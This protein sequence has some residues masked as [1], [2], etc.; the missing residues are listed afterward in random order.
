MD[1]NSLGVKGIHVF[2][3]QKDGA[4]KEEKQEEELRRGKSS[5]L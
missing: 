1:H 3:E 2:T 4:K 5:S